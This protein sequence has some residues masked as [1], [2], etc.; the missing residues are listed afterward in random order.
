M[1]SLVTV[2]RINSN[3]QTVG[4]VR[5][6]DLTRHLGRETFDCL[7]PVELHLFGYPGLRDIRAG[8]DRPT[9]HRTAGRCRKCENCLRHRARLWTA[10]AIDEVKSSQRSWFG[11]LTLNPDEAFRHTVKADLRASRRVSIPLSQ[12]SPEERTVAIAREVT[13]ELTR[14][15]KRVRKNS[16][17]LIR[18]LLVCE[19]HKSGVPHWHYLI[20]EH[21]GRVSKRCLEQAWKLGFS[22]VRLVDGEKPAAYVCKYLA[23]S[24]LTRVRNSK[25]YGA[26]GPRL[27]TERLIAGPSF[28]VASDKEREDARL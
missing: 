26:E 11:T 5:T 21:Q 25:F 12:L 16:G 4:E 8:N 9:V 2:V 7:E 3:R 18:Y 1:G 27:C 14:W 15:L 17:A 28:D 20:H 10:R 24:L 19:P 23:K 13:P 6:R 22:H